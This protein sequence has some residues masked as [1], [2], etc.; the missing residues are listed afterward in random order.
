MKKKILVPVLILIVS[1]IL[2]FIFLPKKPSSSRL[3]AGQDYNVILV[4]IDTLR[5]DR[6]GCYGYAPDV[7]PTIDR[8]AA[9]GVRF[10]E[11]I[12]QTPLTLPSHT[13]IMTGTL[14]I[15]HGVRDNGGFVVPDKLETLAE[16]YKS[17]GF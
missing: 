8:W 15:Y 14:P 10:A 17:A 12:S 5:A 9:Q 1:A 16:S 11:C 4:T 6:V 2:I 3:R 7:T 13:T